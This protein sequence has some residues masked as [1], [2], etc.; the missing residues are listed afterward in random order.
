[1]AEFNDPSTTRSTLAQGRA[2][3]SVGRSNQTGL[4]QRKPLGLAAP[5]QKSANCGAVDIL[6]TLPVPQ[7][8]QWY[9]RLAEQI[10]KRPV[11]GGGEPLASLFL[12]RYLNRKAAQSGG[13]EPLF[14]FTAPDYLKNNER[15]QDMLEQHRNVYLSQ[16]K[17][18]I[19][20]KSRWAGIRP[21]WQKP[22]DYGWNPK[23]PLPMHYQTL[24]ELPL[25][26]QITGNQEEKDLMYGLGLGFQ[27]RTEVIA[28]VVQQS[29]KNHLEVTF[30]QFEA[31]VI[32]RY[33]FNFSE[34]ITVPNPDFNSSKSGAVCPQNKSMTVYHRNARRLEQ[35]GLAAPF[36]LETKVW[37]VGG[38]ISAPGQA[39]LS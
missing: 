14:I 39:K 24:V 30:K 35:A 12:R 32:D 3:G 33:D 20:G 23:D 31:K 27:L 4:G 28:I 21:R 11:A 5:K 8:W 16:E 22:G 34:H 9:K 25:R 29:G 19:G 15:V 13:Q 17:A 7:V 1:M 6:S 37:K 26:W 36:N 10:S 38:S 18:S 2:P